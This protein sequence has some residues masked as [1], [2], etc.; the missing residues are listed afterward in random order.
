MSDDSSTLWLARPASAPPRR[1]GRR[2]F[3]ATPRRVRMCSIRR[4]PPVSLTRSNPLEL[5]QPSRPILLPRTVP[6]MEMERQAIPHPGLGAS[7]ISSL[8]HT[9]LPLFNVRI[10]PVPLTL[11]LSTECNAVCI[12]VRD[13]CLSNSHLNVWHPYDCTSSYWRFWFI[14]PDIRRAGKRQVDELSSDEHLFSLDVSFSLD[15]G[16]SSPC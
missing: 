2:T 15:Q 12:H 9:S 11:F 8:S 3:G 14:F 4:N 10:I 13:G 6:L 16:T 1:P 7:T 5:E